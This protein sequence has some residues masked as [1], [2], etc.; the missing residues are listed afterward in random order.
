LRRR[1]NKNFGELLISQNHI[2]TSPRFSKGV[3]AMLFFSDN[4]N[5]RMY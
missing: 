3:S 5:G 1:A 2:S 4:K